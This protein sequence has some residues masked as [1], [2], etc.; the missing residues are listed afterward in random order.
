MGHATGSDSLTKE[1]APEECPKGWAKGVFTTE[2]T[3]P[4][5]LFEGFSPCSL[6]ALW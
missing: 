4:T 6:C 2:T 3:E 5:E 1:R